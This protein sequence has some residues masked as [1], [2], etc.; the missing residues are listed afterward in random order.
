ME[1]YIRSLRLACAHSCIER[2]CSTRTPQS[3]ELCSVLCSNF[4]GK[5]KCEEEWIRAYIGL[6]H[7]AVYLNLAQH[8]ESPVPQYKLKVT[9]DH[10]SRVTEPGLPQHLFSR[11]D[12][13]L[14][15]TLLIL[16]TLTSSSC[17][18]KWVVLPEQNASIGGIRQPLWRLGRKGHW[19][20]CL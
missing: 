17:A 13:E 10:V 14:N 20:A 15:K 3:R 16:C 8:C 6:N 1:A 2:R 11:R 5:K 18:C 4:Y 7:F 9:V 19:T 12:T